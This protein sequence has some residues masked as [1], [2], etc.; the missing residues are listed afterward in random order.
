LGRG[1]KA[2][3]RKAAFPFA[4]ALLAAL[5]RTGT[6]A[7]DRIVLT[8]GSTIIAD[9]AWYE[10]SQIRYEKNG[11]V[12]GLPRLLVQRLEQQNDPGAAAD[13]DLAKA[14]Q[15]LDAGD[16]EG[17]SRLARQAIGHNPLS[18]PALQL[19]ARACL[20][21]RDASGAADAATRAVRLDERNARSQEL[22][23][24]AL[25]LR[26]DRQGAQAH[27]RRS[28]ELRPHPAVERKLAEVAPQPPPR[29]VQGAE[30]R[31]RYDGGVN[32]PLGIAVLQALTEAHAEF[33]KRLGFDPD[34]PINVVLQAEADFHDG[35]VPGWAEGIND[36]TIRVP[37]RGLEAPT[38]RLLKVLR[39]ELAHS[40]LAARTGGNCP[41]WLQEGVSQ[42][43]E[44]G[45]P[46]REDLAVAKRGRL[47]PLLSLEA[48]F[49]ALSEEDATGAYAES[50]SAVAHII[51][52]RGEA[53]VV[54]LI[55]A[56]GDRLPS[57]EALPVSLALSYSEFQKSWQ[58][59]LATLVPPRP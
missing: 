34:G 26:G 40:F 56:L 6:A 38:P 49:N 53:G 21:L 10:G 54:R 37:V 29:P 18:L 25:A 46:G 3:I 24:D 52:K 15:R 23:G 17:A 35:R 14:A 47:I 12:Y 43:L 48:P 27:Y 33:A 30:F 4:L 42:W 36:G 13:P 45:D 50:L 57:E 16:A 28:I 59:Y 7:A 19:E 1:A 32:E 41:T 2:T 44:G 51:R 39:H 20:A 55:N 58:D 22:L 9:R 11:G 31:I 8:N 5:W